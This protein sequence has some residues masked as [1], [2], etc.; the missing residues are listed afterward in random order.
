MPHIH[1]PGAIFSVPAHKHKNGGGWVA[2]TV[3]IH[4]TAYVHESAWV[5]GRAFVQKNAHISEGAY[6]HGNAVVKPRAIV[7]SGANICGYTVIEH[8]GFN[9]GNGFVLAHKHENGGGW[10]ADTARVHPTAYICP[11]SQVFGNAI[12]GKY[13]RIEGY[14]IGGHTI[15][16]SQRTIDGNVNSYIDLETT[17]FKKCDDLRIEITQKRTLYQW[18]IYSGDTEISDGIAITVEVARKCAK[19]AMLKEIK[20]A[21]KNEKY[22]AFYSKK[23]TFD[24]GNGPV[25]AHKHENGGGWVADSA[26]VASTSYVNC[27]ARVFE[28]A[29]VGPCCTINGVSRVF[30]H[31]ILVEDVTLSGF[32]SITG[33]VRVLQGA[34]VSGNNKYSS[35]NQ[36]QFYDFGHGLVQAHRHK[37]GHG[38]VAD[39]AYVSTE[40]YVGACSVVYGNAQVLG[41]SQVLDSRVYGDV[42]IDNATINDK[43]FGGKIKIENHDFGPG[44]VAAYKCPNGSGWV[45]TTVTL[46][47]NAYID[48]QAAAFDY[49]TVEGRL[50][51]FARA[52]GDAEIDL[53]AIV[54]E[55]AS[56]QGNTKVRNGAIVGGIVVLKD[57]VC[58][59]GE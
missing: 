51:N 25:K 19:D 2:D 11:E 53:G 6:V 46:G 57:N 56:I 33:N 13:V 27:D 34:T 28:Y 30:G 7:A 50:L 39:S 52:S 21:S 18:I 24:F 15:I 26:V 10:V 32:V 42:L 23:D 55:R 36:L 49:A 37:K 14:K 38:W 22:A 29:S 8:V 47:K 43:H 41:A 4:S 20:R 1:F 48:I 12:V 17:A 3:G 40:A 9:F 45:A 35:Q 59:S 44:P 31:A 5:W 58:I 16:H 54:R